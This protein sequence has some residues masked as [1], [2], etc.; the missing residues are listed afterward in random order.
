MEL[1][2]QSKLR[3]KGPRRFPHLVATALRLAWQASPRS[4]AAAAGLQLLGAVAVSLLVVVGKFA[5]DAILAAEDGARTVGALVPVIVLL[6]VVSA[7]GSVATALQSQAARRDGP[8]VP[9]SR[10]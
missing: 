9:A 10:R 1:L 2:L 6:A 4:F 5:L 8:S 7:L 3:R